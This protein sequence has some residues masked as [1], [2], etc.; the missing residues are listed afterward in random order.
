MSASGYFAAAETASDFEPFGCWDG[1]HCVSEHRFEFVETWFSKSD[2][3]V[4]H[5]TGDRASDRVL[6]VSEFLDER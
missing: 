2:W 3:A 5:D 4:S 1:E 6:R